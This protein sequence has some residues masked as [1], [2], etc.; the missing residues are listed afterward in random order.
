MIKPTKYITISEPIFRDL[1]GAKPKIEDIKIILNE[2]RRMTKRQLM[3]QLTV[4]VYSNRYS[5][6]GNES[7]GK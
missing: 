6:N 3:E 1:I 5:D 7:E 4:L 2:K